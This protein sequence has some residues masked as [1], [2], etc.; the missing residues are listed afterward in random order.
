MGTKVRLIKMKILDTIEKM[1]SNLL[2]LN[3]NE[4]YNINYNNL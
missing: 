2:R 3:N 4:H 1:N